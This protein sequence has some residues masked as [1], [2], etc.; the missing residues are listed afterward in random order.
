MTIGNI[1]QFLTD[2]PPFAQADVTYL[3]AGGGTGFRRCRTENI[4]CQHFRHNE[5]ISRLRHPHS[6]RRRETRFV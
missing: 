3:S 2:V 5:L 1:F 6:D 4:F